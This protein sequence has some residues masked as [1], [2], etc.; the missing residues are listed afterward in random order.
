MIVLTLRRAAEQR[1]RAEDAQI[2]ADRSW[3]KEHASQYK[4]RALALKK[5]AAKQPAAANKLGQNTPTQ[6][7]RVQ[8]QRNANA[9]TNAKTGAKA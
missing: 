2:Q 5:T 3:L 1:K 4:V 9:K 7:F 6:A 8:P